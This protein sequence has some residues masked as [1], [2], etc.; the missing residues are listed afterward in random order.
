[1]CCFVFNFNSAKSKLALIVFE[2]TKST[3]K[4]SK[5]KKAFI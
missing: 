3:S 2:L 1:M 4:I 5:L